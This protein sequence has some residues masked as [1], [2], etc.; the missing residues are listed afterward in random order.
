KVIEPKANH[1]MFFVIIAKDTGY[2]V[3]V[4]TEDRFGEYEEQFA[5]VIQ[6]ANPSTKS[7]ESSD[8][9]ASIGTSDNNE[10]VVPHAFEKL[11]LRTKLNSLSDALGI[12]NSWYPDSVI[13]QGQYHSDL[14]CIRVR[15]G[16]HLQVK[17][18]RAD[19]LTFEKLI[20]EAESLSAGL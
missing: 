12:L 16:T 1:E 19:S 5:K 14:E 7:S 17:I 2:H 18:K 20:I 3:Q 15:I 13:I 11:P 10:E 4:E 8:T 6:D 9:E